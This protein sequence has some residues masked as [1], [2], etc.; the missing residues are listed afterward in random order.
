MAQPMDGIAP[1]AATSLRA[2]VIEAEACWLEVR[3]GACGGMTVIPV[4]LIV[5]QYGPDIEVGAYVARLKCKRCAVPPSS[6]RLKESPNDVVSK[7]SGPGWSVLL[8]DRPAV[9][10]SGRNHSRAP[11][12][13]G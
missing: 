11:A 5:G 1:G 12:R 2:H 4:R 13:P 10:V 7:G 6:V 9:S 3:C 8:I